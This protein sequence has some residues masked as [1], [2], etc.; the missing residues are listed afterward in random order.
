MPTDSL[1]EERKAEISE[2]LDTDFDSLVIYPKDSDF[3]GHYSHFCKII[4]WPILHYQVPDGPKSKAYLDHSWV[5]YVKINELFAEKI[6]KN[7]KRGDIIWIH[8]YHLLL[9]PKLIREKLPDA[10]I[11]FFLH[12]AFPS[13]E[14]FR[15]LAF[16]QELLEGMLGADLIGFQTQEYCH[17]FLST[18]NRLLRA[19]SLSH[20]VQLEDRFVDVGTFPIGIDPEIFRARQADLVVHHWLGRLERKYAGKKLI[21]A[22]DKLDIRG[23]RQKLLAFEHL[24]STHPELREDVVM[25]QIASSADAQAELDAKIPWIVSRINT[26]HSTLAHQPL[27]YLKKD[28]E[29]RHYIA[30]LESTDVLMV[31]NLREGMNLAA[32]EY[33]LSQNGAY[34]RKKHGCVILSE[35]IGNA[36]VFDKHDFIVNPWDVRQC[37]E[38]I[39][40]ALNMSE[41]EKRSQWEALHDVVLQKDAKCWIQSFM[42]SLTRAHDQHSRQHTGSIPRLRVDELASNYRKSNQ[43]L[44]VLDYEGTL[45]S[46]GT[47]LSASFISPR[48]IIDTLTDLSTMQGNTVYVMSGRTIQ[49]L[50]IIF[51]C[52]PGLGLIAENGCLIKHPNQ[53]WACLA[54]LSETSKWKDSIQKML[55]Y[56]QERLEGST[57][58]IRDCSIFF[59]TT[60]ARDRQ[61]VARLVGECTN[62]LND[63]CRNFKV[64]AVLCDGGLLIESV[65][66]D[67]RSAAEWIFRGLKNGTIPDFLMVAGDAREDEA[68]YRWANELQE[69][70][71]IPRVC[72]VSVS[73][74][75]TEAMTTLT[76]GVTGKCICMRVSCT[77]LSYYRCSVYLTK[78]GI[79]QSGLI[80]KVFTDPFLSQHCIPI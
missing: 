76:Q 62:Q 71:I 60:K 78:T 47:P 28:L 37:A 13:S 31:T 16:R 75:N 21:V 63:A 73:S 68:V 43:R 8:D 58:N 9:V 34:G 14:V 7:Y 2:K 51:S 29:Y 67:K 69:H 55:E 33:I 20:G 12:V 48:R 26:N 6:V 38:A 61:N 79:Y 50:D 42:T 77:T 45:T 49:E 39:H 74:R 53:E 40:R 17:H 35:F 32:H 57:I 41:E 80:T 22:R 56:Y 27:V 24:L 5:Y 25:I 18:C 30:L 72:T 1:D 52:V 36:A 59:N 11:G 66:F 46:H 65:E 10:Q 54:A 23:I 15:C 44:F 19:E 64:H 70:K 3:D 4:L